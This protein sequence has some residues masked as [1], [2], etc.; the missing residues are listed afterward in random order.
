MRETIHFDRIVGNSPRMVVSELMGRATVLTR[1]EEQGW[2]LSP[3]QAA[4]IRRFAKDR[5]F[6]T[7]HYPGMTA[8]EANRNNRLD[9]AWF[10]DGVTALLGPQAELFTARYTF[11]FF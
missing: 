6:D 7:V 2:D 9:R 8:A 5:G 10:F 11:F 3:D 1:A 4:A